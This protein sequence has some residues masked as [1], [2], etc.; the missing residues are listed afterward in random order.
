MSASRPV[1]DPTRIQPAPEPEI[2][3][4]VTVSQ[5][6]GLIR[7]VLAR[8]LPPVVHVLGEIS[9]ISRPGSG[10]L[11]FTLK[12]E[13]SELRCVMWRSDAVRLKFEPRD[14]MEVIATGCVEVYEGRGQ[15]Q[16]CTRRLEPRGIGALELAF[17]QLRDRLQR[18]GLFDPAIKRR[19]PPY[20]RRIGVVTSASGAA[21]RDILQ[22]LRRRFPC[23]EV[24]LWPVRVQGDGAAR[25]IAEGIAQ[26]NRH[27]RALGG[28]DL[29]IVG[30]GGGS[31]EDLW[32]FN[33]EI[34]ARAIRA[35]LIPI[36]SAV[37]HEVDVTISDLAADVRAP[38]PSAAAEMI[39]P[40]LP[41]LLGMLEDRRRALERHVGYML[42]VARSRLDAAARNEWFRDP[43]GRLAQREQGLDEMAG[44]LGHVLARRLDGLRRRLHR[45][46][47][48][49]ASLRPEAVFQ[50]QHRRLLEAHHR[51]V[52]AFERAG[53][54][55][56]RRLTALAGR[57]GMASPLGRIERATQQL[58]MLGGR[59]HEA[60]AHRLV[61]CR[62]QAEALGARLESVGYRQVLTRGYSITRKADRSRSLITSPQ[63]VRPGDKVITETAAG[64]FESRV[65]DSS[66]LDLFDEQ[67][68]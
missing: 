32:A 44:R 23:L 31:L 26:L 20:P 28:L 67:T 13:R 61:L 6:T 24:V 21:I 66:Q 4:V 60:A 16:L 47:V 58:A 14:G 17:R 68:P 45:C 38:T 49:L 1:F 3:G 34:V 43:L 48:G 62:H 15:Y 65:L 37:G 51:L 8:N 7:G 42:R 35:S 39:V 41:D 27:A 2:R 52:T 54:R 53:W 46:E 50:A 55:R 12:D 63:Q 10:H 64:C 33:E 57:L 30:R 36:V 29:L 5:L 56:E 18:E 40:A 11:Y 59:L 25:E 9:N 19:L 22:V